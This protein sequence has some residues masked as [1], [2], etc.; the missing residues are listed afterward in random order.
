MLDTPPGLYYT[1]LTVD[2]WTGTE[3]GDNAMKNQ[4]QKTQP[5]QIR[6]RF[7]L[8]ENVVASVIRQ[9]FGTFAVV[10]VD[11]DADAALDT[12][13]TFGDDEE[14]A[15]AFARDLSANA[16]CGD[17]IQLYAVAL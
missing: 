13:H 16:L 11:L 5:Q 17:A 2:G 15:T 6:S 14:G 12:I 4:T 9:P 10:V 1:G 7:D 8:G 3:H